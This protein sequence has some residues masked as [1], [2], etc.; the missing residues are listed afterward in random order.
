MAPTRSTYLLALNENAQT[1]DSLS[2]PVF[3]VPSALKQAQ[4][5]KW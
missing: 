3:M 4:W 2:S 1:A 5:A